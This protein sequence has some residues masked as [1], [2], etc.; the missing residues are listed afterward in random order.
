M[1]CK[2]FCLLRLGVGLF[3]V[4]MPVLAHHSFMVY[5]NMNKPITIKGVVTKVDWSNPHISFFVDVKDGSGNVTNWSID[6][7]APVALERRGLVR[8]SLKPGDAI[9]V[10][11]FGAR[12]GKPLAAAS[13][14]SLADG[15]KILA[16]SDG[17]YPR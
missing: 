9:T 13:T 17:A 11:A 7:A 16:G 14:V 15:R 6:A 5:F 1:R 3:L 4:A 10:E 2:V 8:T 12:N